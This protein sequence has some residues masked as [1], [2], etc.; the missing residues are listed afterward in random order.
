MTAGIAATILLCALSSS[1]CLQKDL[2]PSIEVLE[3][4]SESGSGFNV[5][6]VQYLIEPDRDFSVNIAIDLPE[7]IPGLRFLADGM[8]LGPCRGPVTIYPYMAAWTYS[9]F[10]TQFVMVS[11]AGNTVS[12][13]ASASIHPAPPQFGSPY[14]LEIVP[15]PSE[16]ASQWA[17][18]GPV[19]GEFLFLLGSPNR[20]EAEWT[21][22]WEGTRV[23]V[24][25]NHTGIYVLDRPDFASDSAVHVS[26]GG[27]ATNAHA[28]LHLLEGKRA[29]LAFGVPDVMAGNSNYSGTGTAQFE[30]A[31]P[32]PVDGAPMVRWGDFAGNWTFDAQRI[33]QTT[34][35]PLVIGVGWEPADC[36]QLLPEFSGA[37]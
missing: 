19:V 15:P 18:Q 13:N 36:L 10:G 20:V 30:A 34:A 24:S 6:H 17:H 23:L 16:I 8:A 12:R 7:S 35:Y 3:S 14:K 28:E 11:A 9:D 31:E 29:W 26:A 2:S 21:V 4:G 27:F 1:G 33:A 37:T 5:L 25:T 22:A 32:I